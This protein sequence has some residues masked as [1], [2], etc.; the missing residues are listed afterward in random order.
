MKAKQFHDEATPLMSQ[1]RFGTLPDVVEAPSTLPLNIVMAL[2]LR[3][4]LHG[5]IADDEKDFLDGLAPANSLAFLINNLTYVHPEGVELFPF[6]AISSAVNHHSEAIFS[7][8]YHVSR[9]RG[10]DQQH[11]IYTAWINPN[12]TTGMILGFFGPE[13]RL[14]DP[15]EEH[16]FARLV[17]EFRRAYQMIGSHVTELK[18]RLDRKLPTIILNRNSARVVAVNSVASRLMAWPVRALV[19]SH[20]DQLQSLMSSLLSRFRLK[21]DNIRVADLDLSVMTLEPMKQEL[22]VDCNA[23]HYFVDRFRSGVTNLTLAASHIADNAS[24]NSASSSNL[25]EIGQ[26][27]VNEAR[28]LNDVLN[29]FNLVYD[30]DRLSSAQHNLQNETERALDRLDAAWRG[31]DRCQIDCA[32]SVPN[33]SAPEETYAI[34]MAAILRAHN[35]RAET[36]TMIA[37]DDLDNQ[38]KVAIRITSTAPDNS[39]ESPN[40]PE[41]RAFITC[42]IGKLGAQ[43]TRYAETQDD[44]II[45]EI[46]LRK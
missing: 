10:P 21:M 15:D 44:Q 18:T 5:W 13:Y 45:T 6:E 2:L 28:Q 39:P 20:I 9:L 31:K 38:S 4:K 23:H 12:E 8:R 24:D 30:Y 29:E 42:L 11:R 14:G 25:G 33:M 41:E 34:L 16:R 40:R 22:H 46:T 7:H 36:Q 1:S 27:V 37:I 19:N 3:L 35:W 26:I 32:T 17:E 43:I